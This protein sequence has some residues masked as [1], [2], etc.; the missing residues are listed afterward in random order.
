LSS[1]VLAW[2][3][4]RQAIADVTDS[5]RQID[6]SFLQVVYPRRVFRLRCDD[7]PQSERRSSN[8]E[9]P[10]FSFKLDFDH[11]ILAV[12][13]RTHPSTQHQPAWP[14]PIGRRVVFS[15]H[16]D[17]SPPDANEALNAEAE[18]SPAATLGLLR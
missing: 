8:I 12:E 10:T 13:Y 1:D 2:P 18:R 14:Q 7:S 4:R 6:E 11:R 16:G 15:S 17:G 5:R 9:N 3:G